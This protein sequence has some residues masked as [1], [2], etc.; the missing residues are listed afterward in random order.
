MS[1]KQTLVMKEINGQLFIENIPAINLAREYG[2]PCFIY[3]ANEIK[4]NFLK[5][6]DEIRNEDVICYA[7][8]ANSNLHILRLLAELG[9]GF[10]VVS[11]NELERC[12]IAGA[13]KNKIVFSGVSKSYEEI[14]KAIKS[15]ILSI[16]V[17]SLG[18]FE[19]VAEI[20]KRLNKTVNC[21]LRVNPDITIGSHKYIETGSKTS[22]FGLDGESIDKI[23]KLSKEY[24]LINIVAVACHIGSQI[25]NESLILE[26]LE[27]I[28]DVAIKLEQDGHNIEFL[29][30]GGGLGISYKDEDA[31]DPKILLT[32]VKDIL[33]GT[34][35]K[36]VLEPGRSIVGTS[37]IL[38]TKIEYIKDAGDKR[39]AIIDAGMNDL[40]R[41]S[42]Y[43]AWHRVKELE[44]KD[45]VK[46]NYDLAGP[47]CETGDVLARD[48]ELRISTGDYV[49]FMD[50]GAYGSVMSSNYNSRLK[51]IELLVTDDK[52][53]VIKR[54]ES[55]EDM[56]ALES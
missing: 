15:E 51:P 21:A 22:K 3:S 49:A 14:E 54:K 39:F 41:P 43:E 30:I 20:S 23:S 11:G 8:K 25:S 17:E 5:Y 42:L 45:L 33:E 26:S 46:E 44:E 6:K 50:V 32:K 53:K 28:K 48:R 52:V 56:I 13:D 27:C 40:I 10:D 47:V 18:E 38:V 2:S 4:N 7:V 16:N 34:D 37:G 29:D 19:R 1:L 9:S 35:Y 24:K 36:I 12:L 31:G 55:F